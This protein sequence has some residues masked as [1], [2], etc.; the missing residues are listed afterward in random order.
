MVLQ[1]L[2]KIPPH[3][4]F[5]RT[6]TI[7]LAVGSLKLILIPRTQQAHSFASTIPVGSIAK[8]ASPSGRQGESKILQ[9]L[10]SPLPF[11]R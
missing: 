3:N 5:I 6:K 10:C 11:L 4:Q 7:S 9:I 8:V 2:L 1:I